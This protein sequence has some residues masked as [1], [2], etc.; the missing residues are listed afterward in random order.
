MWRSRRIASLIRGQERH[1]IPLSV[2]LRP[3]PRYEVYERR[4]A[5]T[6]LLLPT[7]DC[8]KEVFGRAPRL[9][10]ADAG[11]WSATNREQSEAAGVKQ[12]CVPATGRPSKAQRQQQ[13][14]RWFRRGQR[15]RTGS[16]GRVSVLKRRDGLDRCRYR[17]FSGIQR[18]TGWG[19]LAHN[20]R[21]LINR[22]AR[23]S[24]AH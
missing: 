16:E 14:Q 6:A 8:H 21:L 17:R 2:W 15:W 11:F 12:V 4:P 19:V 10:A 20:I 9:L 24:P 3:R 22:P 23:T 1:F 13:H 7:I 18:W 5:D